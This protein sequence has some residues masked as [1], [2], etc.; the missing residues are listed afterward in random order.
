MVKQSLHDFSELASLRETLATEEPQVEKKTGLRKRHVKS[1][2]SEDE[3]PKPQIPKWPIYFEYKDSID[4][5]ASAIKNY[6]LIDNIGRKI[7]YQTS[8]N[9]FI[10]RVGKSERMVVFYY[11]NQIKRR[12]F[13]CRERFT[14]FKVILF[15]FAELRKIEHIHIKVEESQAAGNFVLYLDEIPVV[16]SSYTMFNGLRKELKGF[17]DSLCAGFQKPKTDYEL[18]AQ[19]FGADLYKRIDDAPYEDKIPVVLSMDYSKFQHI[20]TVRVSSRENTVAG[21]ISYGYN[22]SGPAILP[23]MRDW[24]DRFDHDD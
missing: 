2:V 18:E 6:P 13:Q 9:S 22:H 21:K 19:R 8:K 24:D 10:Y 14:A 1:V 23:S 4:A 3:Q 11:Q 20:E 17:K 16:A 12:V 5:I 15:C 7:T